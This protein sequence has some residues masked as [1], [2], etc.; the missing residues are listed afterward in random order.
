MLRMPAVAELRREAEAALEGVAEKLAELAAEAAR[1]A[2]ENR[3]QALEAA[4]QRDE[5]D[6]STGRESDFEE[7]EELQAALENQEELTSDVDSLR[8]ELEALQRMMEE[9]GQADPELSDE[10]GERTREEAVREPPFVRVIA[11]DLVF[12][13]LFIP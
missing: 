6:P 12:E 11:S 9:A 5:E 1:Q 3:D 8:A 4:A 10:L 7:R 13:Y 2:A